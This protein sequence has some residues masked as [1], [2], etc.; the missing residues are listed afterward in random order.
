ME[1]HISDQSLVRLRRV[2]LW[3]SIQGCGQSSNVP[4]LTSAID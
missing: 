1:S 3:S 4:E 2:T